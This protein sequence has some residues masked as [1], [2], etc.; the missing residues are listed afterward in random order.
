MVGYLKRGKNHGGLNENGK[1][2]HLGFDVVLKGDWKKIAIG[3]CPRTRREVN[4]CGRN[5][6]GGRNV[7]FLFGYLGWIEI[8]RFY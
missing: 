2:K 1:K 4:E 8:S 3:K 6:K 5:E 7:S